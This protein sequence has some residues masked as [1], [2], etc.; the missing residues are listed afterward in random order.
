MDPFTPL[1]TS[2]RAW[3]A[4]FFQQ[5]PVF[6]ASALALAFFVLVARFARRIAARALRH[7]DQTL[8]RMTTSL[9][10]AGLL[11]LGVLAAL[12]IAIPTFKFTEI[13]ASLGVTGLIIGFAL[14]DLIENFV[15]G[16]LILWRRPYRVGDQIQSGSYEGTVAE[17]NFRSTVLKTYDG[18]KVYIPNGK[19]FTEPIENKTGYRERRTTIALGIDQRA[20]IGTAREVI[21]RTL[22]EIDDV[23]DDPPPDVLFDMVGEFTNDLHV[24]FWASPPTRIHELETKSRVTER[25]YEALL[26]ADIGFPYP[27]RTVFVATDDADRAGSAPEVRG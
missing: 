26:A 15:A 13:I 19:A 11:T 9:V 3:T 23:L 24:R 5:L 20:A 18:I 4:A 8:V 25:L 17:I 21:L 22:R 6:V 14:K 1:V 2:V 12:W 7:H 27:T 16:I 10:H